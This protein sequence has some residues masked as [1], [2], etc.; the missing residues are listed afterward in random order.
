MNQPFKSHIIFITG[1]STGIGLDAAQQLTIRGH[2]VIA[3]CRKASDV[4]RLATLGLE[5]ILM[6]VT[7]PISIQEG[8]QCL[9]QK[10]D[11]KLDVLVNNA[12]YGQIGA[13][14]DISSSVLRQQFETNV[15]GL[16]D[17]TR[18]AIPI[19]R[20][21]GHGRIIN[22]SS[23]LGFI[24]MPFRGAYNAS[25]Y[26]V[27]GL[28]DTLR[29]ELKSANIDVSCIQPGPIESQFRVNALKHSLNDLDIEHSAF[30]THYQKMLEHYEQHST[31]N[32]PF[33]KSPEA[34]TQ[35]IIHAIESAKPRAKY[36]VTIPAYLF[37]ILKRVLTT[38]MLDAMIR[39][40]FR[41]P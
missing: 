27:E 36:P 25:K 39:Y 22:V 29:L 8:F 41:K 13:L 19:M 5:V 10:T 15:F 17:V 33:T 11:G 3:S 9:L 26:A 21:Q 34:V 37:M 1:C 20:Q 35:K 38:K 7:D 28:S 30:K 14:E 40:M 23:I 18:H 6:D 24:S 32:P 16:M 4:E 31:I 12:G 2:R